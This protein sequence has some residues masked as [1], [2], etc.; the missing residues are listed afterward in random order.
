MIKFFKWFLISIGLFFAVF[1]SGAFLIPR[2]WVVS[3]N[4]T[5]NTSTN[6]IY[7]QVAN[8]RNW[9]N[10]SVWTKEKDPTQVYT[11]QGPDSG[12]GAKWL[13]TSEK[14]G[15][16][17]LEIK[18][19]N[20]HQGIVYEL[21]IDMGSMQSSLQGEIAYQPSNGALKVIWTDRGDTGNN[22]IKRWMS[23]FIKKMLAD[24][25]RQ[26]LKKLKEITESRNREK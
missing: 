22:L 14:M 17:Y 18:Q 4:I 10:W 11:Y 2:T 25:M 21:F 13:W 20:V 5:I 9:Q 19:A 16:G 1:I 6:A 23:L 12:T 15:Q 7:G 8:L 26:G 24:D 3:E